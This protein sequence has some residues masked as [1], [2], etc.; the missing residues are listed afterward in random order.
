M[1]K[2]Q[3]A[4]EH[5]NTDE[6]QVMANNADLM[7]NSPEIAELGLEAAKSW[8]TADKENS[9]GDQLAVLALFKAWSRIPALNAIVTNRK[10]E[11][12][13]TIAFNI[14]DLLTTPKNE[15]GSRNNA[16]ITAR[17]NAIALHIFGIEAEYVDQAFKNRLNRALEVVEYFV[18]MGFAEDQVSLTEKT[19]KIKGKATKVKVLKVPYTAL[20]DAPIADEDGKI[21]EDKLDLY[22]RLKDSSVVLDG[23]KQ[24]NGRT[25]TVSELQ[26][27][28]K[29]PA[30]SKGANQKK[31][32]D[33]GAVLSSSIKLLN[34]TLHNMTG[35]EA[36]KNGTEMAFNRELRKSLWDTL[37]LLS[38]YFDEVEPLDREEE[39]EFKKQA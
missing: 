3:M 32:E 10:G 11:V 38:V 20:N 26:R 14:P 39:V 5:S 9:K 19:L 2:V 22:N 18:R 6:L 8:T 25:R 33:K 24:E 35:E 31:D 30:E 37:Q 27:R 17:T 12:V 21:D 4:N 15:D 13:E 34:A 28:A 36:K 23:T 29:P 7:K 16:V 1:A